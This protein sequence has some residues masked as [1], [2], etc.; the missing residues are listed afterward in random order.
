[1]KTN[2]KLMVCAGNDDPNRVYPSAGGVGVAKAMEAAHAVAEVL[3]AVCPHVDGEKGD[4]TDL[5]LTKGLEAAEAES[6][7][8]SAQQI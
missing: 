3:V 7:M 8:L 5:L 4:F 6:E 2:R 1:M